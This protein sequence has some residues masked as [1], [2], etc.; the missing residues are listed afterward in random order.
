MLLRTLRLLNMSLG[1]VC[2][3]AFAASFLFEP[4]LRGYYDS[5]PSYDS[6]LIIPTLRV[7]MVI[8]LAIFA[9]AH[10]LIC[11]LLA[12]VETVRT[13]DPFLPENAVRMNTVAWCLLAIQ[14]LDLAFSMISRML[15]AGGAQ[16]GDWSFSITGWVAV[17]LL[18]VLARVFEEGA[19]IRADLEAMV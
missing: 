10:K 9:V 14:L 1:A 2:I 5:R 4:P 16:V 15:K 18:F 13:G 12:I 6:D 19:R 8:G 3:L 11:G 7:G 17:V